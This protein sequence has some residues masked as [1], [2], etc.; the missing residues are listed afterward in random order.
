[1]VSTLVVTT[2][3]AGACFPL[4]F[5]MKG[6]THAEVVV[7]KT[8]QLSNIPASDTQPVVELVLRA[9]ETTAAKNVTFAANSA[10]LAN[11]EG[12]SGILN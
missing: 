7:S 5:L 10:T 11:E 12:K 8:D 4:I 6:T 2:I 1:M 9:M 3:Y